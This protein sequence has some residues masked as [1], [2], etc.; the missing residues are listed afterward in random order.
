MLGFVAS[1][2]QV[3]VRSHLNIGKP[4]LASKAQRKIKGLGEN[5]FR[6]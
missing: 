1:G 4:A 6:K 3:M 5:Y 2:S